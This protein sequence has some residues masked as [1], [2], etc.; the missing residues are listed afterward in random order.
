MVSSERTRGNRHILKYKKFCLNLRKNFFYCEGDQTL[1]EVAQRSCRVGD[2]QNADR[3]CPGQP[4]LDD[5]ALSR[6][7]DWNISVILWLSEVCF[8]SI[9][10]VAALTAL[11]P[12]TANSSYCESRSYWLNAVRHQC[13]LEIMHEWC[14]IMLSL[15]NLW[16]IMVNNRSKI[17]S[18]PIL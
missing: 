15:N 4:V 17:S 9:W 5:S 18:V 8:Q 13:T 10:N 11:S 1:A 7:S 6:G 12:V 14:D 2:I 16:K 3:H